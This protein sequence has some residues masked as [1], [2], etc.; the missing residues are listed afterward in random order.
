MTRIA[1]A[2]LFCWGGPLVVAGAWRRRVPRTTSAPGGLPTPSSACSSTGAC[3]RCSARTNGCGTVG[4]IPLDEYHTTSTGSTRSSSDPDAWVDLAREARGRST[5][6]SPPSTT[7]A[8]ACSTP[9]TT[10]YDIMRT[11]YGKDVL[12]SSPSPARPRASPRFLLLDH[13]LASC[14][15]SAPKTW[16]TARPSEGA[17]LERYVTRYMKPQVEELVRKYDPAVLWFDGEWEH[18]TRNSTPPRWNRRCSSCKP[19]S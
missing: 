19:S 14:R 3:T 7:T 1:H 15:L 8:S 10:D 2:L 6:S 12:G 13:G 11:P 18:S 5:W 16:E 17:D 4:Q 9:I